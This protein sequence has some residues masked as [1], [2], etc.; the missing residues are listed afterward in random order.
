MAEEADGIE[1]AVE[2]QLRVLVTAAGQAG[3]RLARLREES[4]RRAQDS[5]E[6]E[7][8]DLT[9]RMAA[10]QRT[11]RAELGGVHRAE[12]WDRATPDQIG[13]A[14]QVATAWS[15]EDPEAVRAE[16]RIREELRTR[17]GVD[18]GNI[19]PDA[20]RSALHHT[21]QSEA[22]RGRANGDQ[23]EAQ[24]LMLQADQ[25][26]AGR[27]DARV[28]AEHEPEAPGREAAAGVAEQAGAHSAQTREDG[29]S[30]YDS[31]Q[32]R[33]RTARELEDQGIAPDLVGTRMRGDVSQAKP[34]I[35]AVGTATKG[36]AAKARKSRVRGSQVQRSGLDR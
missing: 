23:A 36:K 25:E 2:G 35:D 14:Y 3:E 15:T 4:R 27:D 20:V 8:R 28:A 16:Q 6:R 26:E 9:S 33:A 10:E 1:E 29:T 34:A 7:A 5:S 22:A 31:A 30:L 32:R 17:Y 21:G 11:A 13:H 24:L 19:S 12:W 18:A